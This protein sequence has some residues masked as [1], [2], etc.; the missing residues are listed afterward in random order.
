MVNPTIRGTAA[1]PALPLRTS[2]P[3]ASQPAPAQASALP[4]SQDL[5]QLSTLARPKRQGPGAGAR[6]PGPTAPATSTEV[7]LAMPSAAAPQLAPG[8]KRAA[9]AATVGQQFFLSA[10]SWGM[11]SRL[12]AVGGAMLAE[13]IFPGNAVMRELLST[14]FS[15][16]G[17][18]LMGVTHRH[19]EA[20]LIKARQSV[21]HGAE[22][23]PLYD[24]PT[25]AQ[26]REN[27]FILM[28]TL[29]GAARAPAKAAIPV[30]GFHAKAAL[31]LLVDTLI[32]G[33]A[34]AVAQAV[35][36][37]RNPNNVALAFKNVAVPNEDVKGQGARLF[38]RETINRL[39]AGAYV[40]IAGLVPAAVGIVLAYV[41]AQSR[42]AAEDLGI[43]S[44]TPSHGLNT[45]A[46]G[47][48]GAGEAVAGEASGMS[49]ATVVM[50]A[51]CALGATRAALVLYTWFTTRRNLQ[52]EAVASSKPAAASVE[53]SRKDSAPVSSPPD[54]DPRRIVLNI[55]LDDL[56]EEARKLDA[57]AW[58]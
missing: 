36:S 52:N 4:G 34:G 31:Q 54:P 11:A 10:A 49:T 26:M 42:K 57:G 56:Q 24:H 55:G 19:M 15:L 37:A 40:S 27:V 8:R 32:S 44:T 39:K 12:P 22:L 46:P 9:V 6:S 18:P 38:D 17:G 28:F 48:P 45:T 25:G 20:L 7:S 5:A 43:H 58:I 1:T 47:G 51:Q 14:V 16:P 33:G 35:G 29:A 13:A 21:G 3:Q 2:E 50:L 41:D 30:K 23:Q 53:P